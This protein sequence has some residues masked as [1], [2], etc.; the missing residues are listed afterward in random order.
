LPFAGIRDVRCLGEPA[1]WPHTE[2]TPI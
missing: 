1:A 2:V